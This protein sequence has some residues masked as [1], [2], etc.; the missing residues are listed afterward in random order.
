M[1]VS[2]FLNSF[3]FTAVSESKSKLPPKYHKLFVY[4]NVEK[5]LKI[6]GVRGK[7][8]DLLRCFLMGQC[9]I[10]FNNLGEVV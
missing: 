4:S 10:A 6:Q 9:I 5:I 8:S 3:Y 2:F 7:T 1:N